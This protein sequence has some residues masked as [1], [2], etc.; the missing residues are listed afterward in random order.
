[1]FSTPAEQLLVRP[2]ERLRTAYMYSAPFWVLGRLPCSAQH[3]R[4]LAAQLRSICL[5]G[6]L[7]M[8]RNARHVI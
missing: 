8:I 3:F 6:V 2:A 1:M 5:D 7:Y 4:L